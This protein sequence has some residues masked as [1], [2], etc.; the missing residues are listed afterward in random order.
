VTT[1]VSLGAAL[2]PGHLVRLYKQ[3]LLRWRAFHALLLP[4]QHFCPVS[5]SLPS[6][7]IL[8]LRNEYIML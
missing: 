4:G 7:A 3:L 6:L 8:G 2:P 1:L 5:A